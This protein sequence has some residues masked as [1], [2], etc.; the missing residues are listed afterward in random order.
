VRFLVDK[1]A[2][3][4][5]FLGELRVFPASIIPPVLRTHHHLYFLLP[6]L[7]TEEAWELSKTQR[8]FVRQEHWLEK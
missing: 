7:Q 4:Q 3:G 8:S 5:V 1:V 2:L 6:E